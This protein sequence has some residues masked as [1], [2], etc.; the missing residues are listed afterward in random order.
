MSFDVAAA[1][2]PVPAGIEFE[3]HFSVQ[4]LE[5]MWGL[6][7]PKVRELFRDEEGVVVIGEPERRFKRGY[8][9]LRIPQS[10]VRRVH[11]KLRRR[12]N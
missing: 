12:V 3:R 2:T 9:T 10:V 8:E 6:S 4:E 1:G 5:V 11:A 7:A